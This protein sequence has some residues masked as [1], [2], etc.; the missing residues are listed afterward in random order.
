M[1]PASVAPDKPSRL[2]VAAKCRAGLFQLVKT[3]AF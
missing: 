3:S 2:P 1:L